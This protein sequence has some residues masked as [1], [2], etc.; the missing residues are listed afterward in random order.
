MGDER[1]NP[2]RSTPMSPGTGA[3][4][5]SAWRQA[6]RWLIAV[7]VAVAAFEAIDALSGTSGSSLNG[8]PAD[9]L[10]ALMLWLPVV[11]P[12]LAGVV[13]AWIAPRSAR[14]GLLAAAATV[15]ARI[16][17]DRLTGVLRGAQLPPETGLILIL[18]FGLPWTLTALAG[19]SVLIVAR[20]LAKSRPGL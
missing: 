20:A 17:V 13:A 2:S 7:A 5:G 18:A 11:S 19:G 14:A 9:P 16:G 1:P 12:A 6:G 8:R 4:R 15:W 3:A 10:A